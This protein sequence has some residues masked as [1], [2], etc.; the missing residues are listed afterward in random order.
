MKVTVTSADE[1]QGDFETKELA[2]QIGEAFFTIRQFQDGLSIKQETKR[3]HV[4]SLPFINENI[5]VKEMEKCLLLEC[6][7]D[8][9]S[10]S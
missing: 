1:S 10:V 6:L 2:I 9:N 5:K 7:E 3:G 4:I 8:Q